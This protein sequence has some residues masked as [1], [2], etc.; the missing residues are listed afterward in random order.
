MYGGVIRIH[1]DQE[2]IVNDGF[3]TFFGGQNLIH[4]R[5]RPTV[6]NGG[7]DYRI[8]IRWLIGNHG[9]I[10]DCEKLNGYFRIR[11]LVTLLAGIGQRCGGAAVHRPCVGRFCQ[12]VPHYIVE[13][14]NRTTGI[15]QRFTAIVFIT[16]ARCATVGIGRE[17]RPRQ[18]FGGGDVHPVG[19]IPA[20]QCAMRS[21]RGIRR[22]GSG[23]EPEVILSAFIHP[24]DGLLAEVS[25]SHADSTR[26]QTHRIANPLNH[27][28]HAT[29]AGGLVIGRCGINFEGAGIIIRCT[30]A[31]GV[32][33][34]GNVVFA[35]V[36]DEANF[37]IVNIFLGELRI[38]DQG[39]PVAVDVG[40]YVP[41]A[42]QCGEGIDGLILRYNHD[43]TG[44]HILAGNGIGKH[45]RLDDIST[46]GSAYIGF[47]PVSPCMV[48]GHTRSRRKCVL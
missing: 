25:I 42:R 33:E 26:P 21:R 27:P 29:A 46:I 41:V 3:T 28:L 13:G 5:C 44:N 20:L 8:G 15:G 45:F 24:F 6:I 11:T 12:I 2:V 43:L 19:T 22:Q 30:V 34:A 40:F 16:Q 32:A 17:Q 23:F 35:V 4:S 38:G 47:L 39:N 14:N 7:S 36:M 31:Y 18:P 37:S 48:I 10:I 9:R 1:G